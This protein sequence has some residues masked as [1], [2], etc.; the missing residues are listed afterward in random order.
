MTPAGARSVSAPMVMQLLESTTD[1]GESA[2]GKTAPDS[3]AIDP[4]RIHLVLFDLDGT[5]VDSVG[6][7]GWCGQQMRQRLGL[8]S[9]SPEMARVWVGNGL[10]RFVKRVL[11]GDIE[12][13]PPQPLYVSGLEIFRE[14]YAQHASDRCTLYPGVLE[15]LQ[16][17][18]A[19]H[20][21]LACVTNK[22]EPF[23]SQLI[24][25]MG[26]D[27]FFE[28]VVAGDTTARKKPDPMPLHY[29]ADHFGL[30]YRQ[31]L[32]VGDS[33]NDVRAARA[34]GFAIVCVPYGYNHGRDIRDSAPDLVVD[35]L[36]EL[37]QLLS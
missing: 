5:L 13:E 31:C 3:A 26:L 11:T 21:K 28:L 32:M 2:V 19:S 15:T 7:L 6:D 20:L 33:S 14:L 29:A 30:D 24:E 10:E 25:S 34:A 17:L 8:P 37:V 36:T 27:S 12:A 35:N 9:Q 18:G 23:T 16:Q 1:D 22:P 4:Q